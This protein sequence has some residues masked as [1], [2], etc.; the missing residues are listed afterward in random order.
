MSG[1]NIN[2]YRYTGSGKFNIKHFMTDDTGG[3]NDR[4]E[5]F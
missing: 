5:V 3:M 2:A 4:E 1:K